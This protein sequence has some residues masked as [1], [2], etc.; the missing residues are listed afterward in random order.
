L[1]RTADAVELS[2]EEIVVAGSADRRRHRPVA[3]PTSVS[4]P[5]ANIQILHKSF[6]MEVLTK[7]ISLSLRSQKL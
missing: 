1:T 2:T 5:A 3:V 4:P 6:I 7:Y